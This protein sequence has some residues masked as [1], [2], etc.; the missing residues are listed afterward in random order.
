MLSHFEAAK[1][2]YAKAWGFDRLRS[3]LLDQITIEMITS[4]TDTYNP[5]NVGWKVENEE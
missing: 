3:E 4:V 1:K 5:G 2:K